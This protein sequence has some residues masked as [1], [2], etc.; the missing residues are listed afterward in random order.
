MGNEHQW[1]LPT[2]PII[3]PFL[4]I[5]L[6]HQQHPFVTVGRLIAATCEIPSGL[7]GMDS[8]RARKWMN[9]Y[10]KRILETKLLFICSISVF[11]FSPLS[12]LFYPIPSLI[13]NHQTCQRWVEIMILM[14]GDHFSFRDILFVFSFHILHSNSSIQHE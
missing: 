14:L 1:A 9:W 13:H 6:Q 2:D 10:P 4:F 7:E 5:F 3:I 12:Y 11:L 8:G